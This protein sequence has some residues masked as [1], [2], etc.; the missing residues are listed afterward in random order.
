VIEIKSRYSGKVLYTAENA[1][2]VREALV[3]AVKGSADLRGAY[4]GGADLGGADLGG[5][6]LGG[7][8]LG[9][10]DL[11][12]AYLGG[13]DLGGAYLR[14][15]YLGGAD[16]GGADLRGAYL[17]GADLRGADL[18]SAV[19]TQVAV[20]LRAA[21]QAM[22]DGGKHWIK[23]A[24]EGALADG[25]KTYC[26]AGSVNASSEG[27][28]RAVALWLLSSVTAGPVENFNDHEGTSWA[29]V[30]AVFRVAIRNAER[31]AED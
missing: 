2:D 22:N 8:D 3:E 17:R 21:L 28:V 23:G 19:W 12:G 9:G 29:D 25:S 16:L 1:A 10:A 27:T 4:L 13:A 15:A 5:A 24:L 7:A 18:G 14:G 20:A 30:E 26:A 31:F 6:D 11:R